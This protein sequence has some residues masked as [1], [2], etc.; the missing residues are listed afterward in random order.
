MLA[1]KRTHM[2]PP[3]E[4]IPKTLKS[5]KSPIV[6]CNNACEKSADRSRRP[7]GISNSK[8]FPRVNTG[9]LGD[10]TTLRH[11]Y[12]GNRLHLSNTCSSNCASKDNRQGNTPFERAAFLASFFEDTPTL[13]TMLKKRVNDIFHLHG[14]IR[15]VATS[16]TTRQPHRM[17]ATIVLDT[18]SIDPTQFTIR[19]RARRVLACLRMWQQ[20]G[21]HAK[22]AEMEAALNVEPGW[23]E[24][25]CA[26]NAELLNRENDEEELRRRLTQIERDKQAKKTPAQLAPRP[27][28]ADRTDPRSN[29]S[30]ATSEL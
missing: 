28:M 11:L 5:F 1:S 17:L 26:K 23:V 6:R 29:T 7:L 30:R 25:L 9:S 15:I 19:E 24:A 2:P 13:A 14:D 10:R 27:P 22:I 3:S 8:K 20:T 4:S 16:D 21:Q 12:R 18:A